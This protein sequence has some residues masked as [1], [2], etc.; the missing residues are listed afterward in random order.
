MNSYA[1]V[2]AQEKISEVITN[3]KTCAHS[4]G[5]EEATIT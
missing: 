4:K 1:E 5:V 3:T 2:K